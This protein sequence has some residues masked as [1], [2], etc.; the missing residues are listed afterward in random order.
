MGALLAAVLCQVGANTDAKKYT[1]KQDLS[2]L[3]SAFLL[4]HCQEHVLY[5]TYYA[6]L[7]SSWS[8]TLITLLFSAQVQYG[9]DHYPSHFP[10]VTNSSHCTLREC[11]YL[12]VS[13]LLCI[14]VAH[15][16][17]FSLCLSCLTFFQNEWLWDDE[18]SLFMYLFI[19]KQGLLT[20]QGHSNRWVNT[21]LTEM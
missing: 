7:H 16:S 12:S 4:T 20:L 8:D 11:N 6:G 3:H 18:I 13:E 2:R 17:P 5:I 10:I 1:Q 14:R 19:V 21:L 15:L 9:L